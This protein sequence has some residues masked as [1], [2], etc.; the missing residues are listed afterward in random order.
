MPA[1][2]EAMVNQYSKIAEGSTN[3]YNI[4]IYDNKFKTYTIPLNLQFTPKVIFLDAKTRNHGD[5]QYIKVTSVNQEITINPYTS[6]EFRIKVLSISKEKLEFQFTYS[7]STG[8]Y[9]YIQKFFAI[10]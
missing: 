7:Y 9:G 6:Y 2:I 4:N 8:L 5:E 3:I 10:G 1:N